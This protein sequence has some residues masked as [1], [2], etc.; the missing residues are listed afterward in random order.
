MIRKPNEILVG[1]AIREMTAF[2]NLSGRLTEAG[3]MSAWEKIVGTLIARHTTN[4]YIKHRKLYVVVNSSVIR[5]ELSY[6]RSK[7]VRMLNKEAGEKVIDEV[8]LM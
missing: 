2:Y 1:D 6:V 4:L 8:V 5:S 3:V 7:L